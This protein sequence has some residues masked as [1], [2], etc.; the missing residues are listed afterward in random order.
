MSDLSVEAWAVIAVII[1]VAGYLTLGLM[2][3][4]IR[5]EIEL[6]KLTNQVQA[7]RDQRLR[8]PA[9]R[10]VSPGP[11]PEASPPAG[12]RREAA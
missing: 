10:R 4:I 11:R 8:A 1:G 9:P 2:A 6:D 7:L 5:Y 3:H 12:E